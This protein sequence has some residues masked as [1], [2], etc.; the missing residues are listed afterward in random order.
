MGGTFVFHFRISGLITEVI[1]TVFL[2]FVT[3]EVIKPLG[4][5]I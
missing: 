2:S 1:H 3:N 4:S 5:G